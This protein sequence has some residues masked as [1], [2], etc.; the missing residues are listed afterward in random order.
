MF[1]VCGHSITEV[2]ERKQKSLKPI[3]EICEGVRGGGYESTL[4][5]DLAFGNRELNSSQSISKVSSK[6]AYC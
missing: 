5:S 3:Q 6:K 1:L 4:T 2:V